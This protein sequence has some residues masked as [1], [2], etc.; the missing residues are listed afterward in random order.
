MLGHQFADLGIEAKYAEEFRDGNIEN[1]PSPKQQADVSG[2]VTPCPQ[3]SILPRRLRL[4]DS[5][6]SDLCCFVDEVQMDASPIAFAFDKVC[7]VVQ[8]CDVDVDL[9]D[10][11]LDPFAS[12]DEFPRIVDDLFAGAD[13]DD[14]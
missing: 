13:K 1:S 8:R 4:G 10:C 12:L 6:R 14:G 3:V 11:C 5:L 9:V 7:D 2:V